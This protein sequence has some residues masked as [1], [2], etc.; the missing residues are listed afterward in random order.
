MAQVVKNQP[1]MQETQNTGVW[2]PSWEGG[3]G[4]PLQYSRLESPMDRGIWQTIVLEATESDTTEPACT[5]Y[6][7][8]TVPRIH[9]SVC[10]CHAFAHLSPGPGRHFSSYQQ[11]PG[12]AVHLCRLNSGTLLSCLHSLV[13]SYVY[14]FS[15]Y[16]WTT[17][18]AVTILQ[19][20]LRAS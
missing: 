4:N 19:E 18:W 12:N 8:F 2:S 13:P 20:S 5:I 6:I 10:R 14:S 1:A 17:W 7:L 11:V 16:L 9:G 15:I 3:N